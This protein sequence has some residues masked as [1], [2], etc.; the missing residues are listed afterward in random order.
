MSNLATVSDFRARF[1]EFDCE[2][3]SSIQLALDDASLQLNAQAWRDKYDLGQLY[4]AAHTLSLLAS[5]SAESPKGPVVSETVGSVSRTYANLTASNT[6]F[7][8]D[9]STTKYGMLYTR[10]KRQ[11]L[12]TPVVL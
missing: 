9:T 2:S 6:S 1:E 8:G 3:D 4:L 11:I 5:A 7:A 10:L 12:A